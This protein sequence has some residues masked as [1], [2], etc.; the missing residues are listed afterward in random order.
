MKKLMLVI[1]LLVLV[2]CA[3]QSVRNQVPAST[4]TGTYAG[5]PYNFALPKD[6][7][8]SNLDVSVS[9]NGTLHIHIDSATAAEN[10]AVITM[11]GT[12]YSTM[13]AADSQLL[14]NAIASASAA[15][16]NVAGATV[17]TAVTK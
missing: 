14:D 13:R 15:I 1:P 16:G 7:T 12:A 2:G 6:E 17:K 5:Q 10:P 11:T 4:F 9:T 3:A 8:F